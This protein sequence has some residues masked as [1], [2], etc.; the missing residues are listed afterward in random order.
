MFVNRFGDSMDVNQYPAQ[1]TSGQNFHT[2]HA[3]LINGSLNNW[4]FGRSTARTI[5]ADT[6]APTIP[7]I[8]AVEAHENIPALCICASSWFATSRMSKEGMRGK[9]F[10]AG[11]SWDIFSNAAIALS[12]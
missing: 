2:N 5:V 12:R 11:V 4:M 9:M 8:T 6:S 3:P 10:P 1:L 7:P